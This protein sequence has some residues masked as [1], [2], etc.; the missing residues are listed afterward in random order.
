[1]E[2]INEPLILTGRKVVLRPMEESHFDGLVAASKHEKIWQ[3]FSYNGFD[4]AILLQYQRD[5]LDLRDKQQHYPFT[6]FNKET[7]EIIGTTRFGNISLQHNTLEIGWTWYIPSLWGK[8]YNEE[9][10]LLLL[11]YCFEQWGTMRVELKTWEK[12]YR[13]RRAIERIGAS[14]EGTLRNHMINANGTIRNTA[15]YS[16]IEE[17]WEDRKPRLQKITDEKYQLA[18]Q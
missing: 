4:T 15:L 2:W 7:G 14:F 12:N 6:I 11:T 9:C 17:E 18:E 13:S 1:M 10:K 3:F 8:G 16:I 5:A